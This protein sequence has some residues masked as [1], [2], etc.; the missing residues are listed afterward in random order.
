MKQPF[1]SRGQYRW[2]NFSA[3]SIPRTEN[4]D[5]FTMLSVQA[6]RENKLHA[7]QNKTKNIANCMY[8]HVLRLKAINQALFSDICLFSYCNT[9]R[10]Q[11][12]GWNFADSIFKFIYWYENCCVLIH[13]LLPLGIGSIGKVLL[14]LW[15]IL[16]FYTSTPWSSHHLASRADS[17]CAPSQWE[18]ALLCND[19]YHWLGASLES[20]LGTRKASSTRNVYRPAFLW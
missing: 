16:S 2:T 1:C 19:I 4:P 11:Q 8:L 7:F 9:L 13:I 10:P 20:A 5:I 3:K 18:T 14:L 17:R 6:W 12:N 15:S